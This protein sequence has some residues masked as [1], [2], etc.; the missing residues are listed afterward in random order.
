MSTRAKVILLR[1]VGVGAL[2]GAVGAVMREED[3]PTTGGALV[4]A[5]VVGVGC[6]LWANAIVRRH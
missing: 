5:A 4:L 2:I 3:L 1:I 6:L